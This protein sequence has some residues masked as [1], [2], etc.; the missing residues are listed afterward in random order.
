MK[1]TAL[2][3]SPKVVGTIET[4]RAVKERRVHKIFLAD[5]VDQDIKDKIYEAAESSNIDVNIVDNKLKL[6]RACGIDV[7]AASAALL[8]KF[9]GGEVYANN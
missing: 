8:K 2:K 1:L 9:E 6:G 4:L 3:V 7:A 5:D